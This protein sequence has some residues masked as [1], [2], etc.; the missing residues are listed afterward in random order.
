ME[1]PEDSNNIDSKVSNVI[2]DL[3]R[4]MNSYEWKKMNSLPQE[5]HETYVQTV[6]NVNISTTKAA[7]KA[8]A[9]IKSEVHNIKFVFKSKCAYEMNKMCN[10][11][12]DEMSKMHKD[13]NDALDKQKQKYQANLYQQ[14]KKHE[15]ELEN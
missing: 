11:F 7:S 13:F 1:Q 6:N 4:F 12:N 10:D 8:T 2:H 9:S 3:Q 14:F 5:L 15:L